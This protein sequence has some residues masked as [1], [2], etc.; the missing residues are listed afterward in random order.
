MFSVMFIHEIVV[1]TI[2]TSRTVID[3]VDSLSD[4]EDPSPEL[5]AVI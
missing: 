3:E 2:C 4:V 1:L 5:K